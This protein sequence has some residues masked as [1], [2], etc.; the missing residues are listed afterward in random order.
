M[1]DGMIVVGVTAH[2][3]LV[4]WALGGACDTQAGKLVPLDSSQGQTVGFDVD[5]S[6]ADCITG[7]E[8]DTIAS[9]AGAAYVWVLDGGAWVEQ[10]KLI[11]S[12]GAEDDKFGNGVAIDGDTA[13]VGAPGQGV[14]FESDGAA[15]IFTRTGGVWSE[16]QKLDP[17]GDSGD[18]FGYAVDLDG[19]WMAI[20]ARGDDDAGGNAGAVYMYER[21]GGTWVFDQKLAP[22]APAGQDQFAQSLHLD[23][24][25]LVVS[26]RGDDDVNFQAGAVYVYVRTGGGWAFEQKLTAS[27]GG[28]NDNLGW[29]V[30][31]EGDRLIAGA[32][33]AQGPGGTSG[34]AYIFDRA[35]GV[36]NETQKI[37]E[38]TIFSASS[39]F[40]FSVALDGGL[41]YAG[42]R[43]DSIDIPFNSGAVYTFALEGGVWAEV[44]RL[45]ASDG[46]NGDN[47]GWS[48]AA[49]TGVAVVGSVND[50]DGGQSSGAGYVFDTAA[51]APS[52]PSDP[53]DFDMDGDVDSADL[54]TLLA[55]F[56]C[57]SP[58]E[59]DCPGDIDGDGDTDSADLNLL[60]TAFGT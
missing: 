59:P 7:S 25:T 44:G 12:D 43:N 38:G 15:Y 50:D 26:A 16:A 46:D 1:K 24:D 37:E 55:N 14:G 22:P 36:W 42:A 3:G 34:V 54:N 56:G 10:Q 32:P 11:A 23:G 4:G 29:S 28:G 20:G 21:I 52:P 27:D 31:V 30:C 13:V 35:G 47:F 17:G 40:G 58:P 41:A 57:V 5:I 39:L 45:T 9:N 33:F 49:D 19:G 6:G 2:L 8:D 51:C 48:M 53:A 60:L 18:E